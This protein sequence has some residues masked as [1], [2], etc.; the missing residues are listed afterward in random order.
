[1]HNCIYCILGYAGTPGYLSP[2]VVNK[3]KYGK[4]I[5]VW[6]CGEHHVIS[7]YS[8]TYRVRCN[9]VHTTCWLPSILG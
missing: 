6:A 8:V 2:E 9:I 7:Q 3:E 1:M 4:A 5:D